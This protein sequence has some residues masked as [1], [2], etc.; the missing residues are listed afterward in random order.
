[1][2]AFLSIL[3]H[4][5]PGLS[6]AYASRAAAPDINA[7][8]AVLLDAE[9]GQVLYSKNP[10]EKVAPASIT[11]IM[12]VL[13]VVEHVAE[14]R[15][16]L[17]DIV[18]V[19]AAASLM[20]GSQVYLRHNEKVPVREL[21]AAAAIRS[22]NDACFALAEYV[23][24]NVDDFV[25]L[26]NKRASELG[27]ENTHF[28]NPEGLDNPDHYTTT[29]DIAVMAREAVRHP[30][31][32]GWTS[33]WIGK[34]RGGTYDLFNTNRLIVSYEGADGLKTGYTDQAGY[35]LAGTAKREDTRLIAVVMGAGSEK[36][37][38]SETAKL[39]DYG[40]GCLERVQ[41]VE[42]GAE[43][44][45]VNVPSAARRE[46]PVAAQASI[47]A[48]VSKGTA[49]QVAVRIEPIKEELKAPIKK[50]Q[51]VGQ[52][53][54]VDAYGERIGITPAV[55]AEDVPRASL[56]VRFFRAIARLF[57]SLFRMG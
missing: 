52:I 43:V 29:R 7:R 2:I 22:A 17:D 42:A 51:T 46:V 13:L 14:G 53:V 27:M 4:L 28:A 33:T 37:R 16:S 23:A 34:M 6:V 50:G 45:T 21:L 32:L 3:L 47:S 44:G 26:M 10:D 12:T 8:S 55:A 36:E 49:A 24:G 40:F 41:V 1:L 30:E 9:T 56:I 31:I 19:S 57:S 15:I 11:K 48:L 5:V 38:V 18:T 54:A 39:L 20:G 25:A 35:C